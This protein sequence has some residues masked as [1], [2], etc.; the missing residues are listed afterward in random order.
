[1]SIAFNVN[2]NLSISYASAEDT[3]DDQS[4]TKGGTEVVDVSMDMKSIQAA[5]SMGAMS[6]KAYRTETDNAAYST[7]GGS[8]TVN[9]VALGLSF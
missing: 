2:D 8:L 1:M 6:I 4:N 5:Y 3:Y 7:L 9:E